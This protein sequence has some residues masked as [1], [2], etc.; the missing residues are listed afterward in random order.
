MPR[1]VVSLLCHAMAI[2]AIAWPPES[3]ARVKPKQLAQLAVV[4]CC[5]CFAALMQAPNITRNYFAGLAIDGSANVTIA[6]GNFSNNRPG[7]KSA[8][9]S[10]AMVVKGDAV[11]EVEQSSFSRNGFRNSGSQEA[12]M[13]CG[14]VPQYDTNRPSLTVTD[15][16]QPYACTLQCHRPQHAHL[17]SIA[18]CSGHAWSQSARHQFDQARHESLIGAS[19]AFSMQLWSNSP[20]CCMYHDHHA[21]AVHCVLICYVCI[22][23]YH[24]DVMASRFNHIH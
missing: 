15:I 1:L 20:P 11:V 13:Q 24:Y 16:H 6:N 4:G 5:A 8:T 12:G 21:A 10:G 2:M 23:N 9:T 7:I 14:L 3:G 22:W 18:V 17:S 19:D